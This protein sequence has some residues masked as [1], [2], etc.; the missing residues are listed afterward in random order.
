MYGTV[1]RVRV[2]PGKEAEF[3]ALG[4][5]EQDLK[6]PGF[7]GQF[8]YRLD[9]DANEYMLV[10]LFADKESYFANADSPEQDARYRKMRELFDAEP[11]WSDGEIVHAWTKEGQVVGEPA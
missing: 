8:V 2:K 11:E 9:R 6:I 10:V 4:S 1:G 7:R 5:E 3:L